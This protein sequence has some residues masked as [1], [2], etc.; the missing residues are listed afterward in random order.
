M[1][2]LR[3]LGA[4]RELLAS[5]ARVALSILLVNNV[6][7]VDAVQRQLEEIVFVFPHHLALGEA[8][9][10]RG[11]RRWVRDFGDQ[12]RG[13]RLGNS[14]HENTNKRKLQHDSEAKGK[15]KQHTLAV[16]EP[17]ALLLRSKLD[18]AEVWFKLGNC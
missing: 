4:S 11:G 9:A 3:Y 15:P 13:G 10:F 18:A 17:A 1:T 5:R 12:I 6:E 8:F 2:D 7:L 14:V 16:T